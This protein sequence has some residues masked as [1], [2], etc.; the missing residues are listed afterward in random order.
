MPPV[1]FHR[2]HWS[3]FWTLCSTGVIPSD[4]HAWRGDERRVVI[5]VARCR[6]WGDSSANMNVKSSFHMG[7]QL[8]TFRTLKPRMRR[9]HRKGKL[10]GCLHDHV[11]GS[12]PF[13][14]QGLPTEESS[15]LCWVCRGHR[16]RWSSI[17]S[18]FLQRGSASS[19]ARHPHNF[20]HIERGGPNGETGLHSTTMFTSELLTHTCALQIFSLPV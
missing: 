16:E 10:V 11:Q 13:H 2:T 20:V 14:G 1:L 17:S 3:R 18:S 6:L 15:V 7:R 12:V 4:C 9:T 8:E 19:P 5:D